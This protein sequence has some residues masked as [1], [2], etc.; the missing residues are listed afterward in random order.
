MNMQHIRGVAQRVCLW[1][2]MAALAYAGGTA[3]YAEIAQRYRS[4]AFDAERAAATIVNTVKHAVD[5]RDGDDFGVSGVAGSH[6]SPR[7]RRAAHVS[8]IASARSSRRGVGKNTAGATSST[9]GS[10]REASTAAAE[11]RG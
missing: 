7:R 3:V 8:G 5:L 9:S 1:F 11:R 10:S 2:G 6:T 4:S